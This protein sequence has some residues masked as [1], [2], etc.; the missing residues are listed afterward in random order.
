MWRAVALDCGADSANCCR[1]VL[2]LISAQF[3]C[4]SA[5]AAGH[6]FFKVMWALCLP[7]WFFIICNSETAFIVV[8]MCLGGSP[9]LM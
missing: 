9:L 6:T 7:L 4:C 1:A 3:I 2:C 8:F 5:A